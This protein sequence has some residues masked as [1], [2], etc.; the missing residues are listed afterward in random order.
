MKPI[1]AAQTR[2]EESRKRR[3]AAERWQ[4]YIQ[5]LRRRQQMQAES[6]RRR[7]W[8]LLLLLWALE[9]KPAQLF[10]PSPDPAPPPTTPKRSAA[11]KSEIKAAVETLSDYDRHYLYDHRPRRG[12][13]HLE[14][15]D[16]LTWN[17]IIAY[18][19]IHRPHL[20]P[21]FRPIPGMP[22]RYADEPVNVW[23]LFDH[24]SSDYHRP[25]AI[26]ALKLIVDSR[27]H[28]WI[29]ACATEVGDLTY[30]DLRRQCKRRTPAMTLHEFPRAATW[31]RE[32]VRREEEE[33]KRTVKETS[34][35][36]PKLPGVD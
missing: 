32:S 28:D 25:D 4:R 16:G 19:R 23:T 30:K 26:K 12:E 35:D 1:T 20:F 24:M 8:L 13:E 7:K 18:N 31:W 27:A 33:K 6:D 36:A 34:D 5:D 14:V 10:F 17:D 15:Y 29:D 3:R 9:S 22:K 21:A 11:R 2:K